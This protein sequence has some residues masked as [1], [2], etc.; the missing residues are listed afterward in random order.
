M[1]FRWV[2]VALALCVAGC[3]ADPPSSGSG[4]EASSGEPSRSS[5]TSS[6]EDD[7]TS[8]GETS[9]DTSGVVDSSSGTSTGGE[10]ELFSAAPPLV[11][12]DIAVLIDTDVP[13]AAV[14]AA[15]NTLSASEINNLAIIVP[16]GIAASID[17]PVSCFQGCNMD[18]CPANPNRIIVPY[19]PEG[20]PYDTLEMFER[21][22]CVFREPLPETSGPV[23]H[24]WFITH[25]PDQMPPKEL[26]SLVLDGDL[27]LRVHVSCPECTQELLNAN[28]LL[29]Q[30][31]SD[32]GGTVSDYNVLQ[33]V[34]MQLS[35]LGE[36]RLSCA[37]P[38]DADPS[39]LDFV[40]GGGNSF[41]AEPVSEFAACKAD[42]VLDG[43]EGA[44][45]PT[46]FGV[47]LCPDTCQV[48]QAAPADSVAV[49]ECF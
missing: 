6:G 30:V 13:T 4:G 35:R 45:F 14:V 48:V 16:E 44:F 25:R 32:S 3:F 33:Q 9:N 47:A 17:V 19:D 5:S 1:N 29:E 37:W 43:G 21:F 41:F 38:T 39:L 11:P 7:T 10:C 40:T 12:A 18:G 15:L 34:V 26:A 20:S 28:V 2:S 27:S 46:D 24:L 8:T 42:A 23:S 36:E 31:V 49:S 22:D